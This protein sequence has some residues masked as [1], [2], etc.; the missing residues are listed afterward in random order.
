GVWRSGLNSA[1]FLRDGLHG[2]GICGA[3]H[4]DRLHAISAKDHRAVLQEL[5]CDPVPAAFGVGD[6]PLPRRRPKTRSPMEPS[7]GESSEARVSRVA[8]RTF[9]P[10]AGSGAACRNSQ[11]VGSWWLTWCFPEG[12]AIARARISRLCLSRAPR[13]RLPTDVAPP[14][15]HAR[16]LITESRSV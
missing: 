2:L 5:R 6:G 11:R 16:D 15:W 7:R 1:G 12:R 3:H 10:G 9:A 13:S 14:N 8:D 4:L